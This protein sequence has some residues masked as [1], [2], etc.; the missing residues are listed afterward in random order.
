M[1][2]HFLQGLARG[3]SSPYHVYA[4]FSNFKEERIISEQRTGHSPV[5][6]AATKL[7]ITVFLSHCCNFVFNL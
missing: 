4:T 7:E 6:P 3:P 2:D 5:N 1:R